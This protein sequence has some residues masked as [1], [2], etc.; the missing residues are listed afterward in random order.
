MAKNCSYIDLK[1]NKLKSRY[2][3]I[4]KLHKVFSHIP[5][6]LFHID[7]NSTCF[8]CIQR[9]IE[10]DR[11]GIVSFDDIRCSC[12]SYMFYKS[13]YLLPILLERIAN[14]VYIQDDE[15]FYL[16]L[17]FT[18]LCSLKTTYYTKGMITEILE[19][20]KYIEEL[21]KM[22]EYEFWDYE[23]EIMTYY[24][25][26]ESLVKEIRKAIKHIEES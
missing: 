10:I 7:S 17:F 9:H 15:Y 25:D 4:K 3:N 22:K 14:E 19:I 21:Y 5:K 6:E 24:L 11:K 8:E 1:T 26:N 23:N 13:D 12:Y 20:L 18:N 16:E 2:V